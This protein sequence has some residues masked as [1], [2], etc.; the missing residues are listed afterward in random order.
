[1]STSVR[2]TIAGRAGAEAEAEKLLAFRVLT[3]SQL[4]SRGLAVVLDHHLGLSVRQWRVVFYLAHAGADSVQNIADFCRYDKSQV[5][6]AVRELT[7]KK[8]V[9][10]K[11]GTDDGRQRVVALTAAG[12][13]A[14]RRGQ[15]LSQAR[16]AEL[17]ASLPA[18]EMRAFEKSLDKLL[19]KARAL[20]DDA[21]AQ[22]Q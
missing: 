4:L 8:L 6:R 20:L 14:F 21:H 1:M 5:S 9:T 19:G 16:H 2:K 3:L 12:R 13:A 10:T 17:A 18:A 15:P 11:V 7:E 22:R